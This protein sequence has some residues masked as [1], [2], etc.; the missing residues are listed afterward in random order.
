MPSVIITSQPS[1]VSS[2]VFQ[3]STFS[4]E[5]SSDMNFNGAFAGYYYQW[6][7]GA[8]SISG[9]N[10]SSY[11]LDPL[12]TD[13]ASTFSVLVSALSTTATGVFSQATVTSSNANLAVSADNSPFAHLS[14]FPE[15]GQERFARLRNLGYV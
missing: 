5:V 7:K 6:R 9:A 15:S 8:T 1:N 12:L 13:N 4:V 3:N 14:S 11:T 2:V 10:G